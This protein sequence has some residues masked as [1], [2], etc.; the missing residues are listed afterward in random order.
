M[1]END[2]IYIDDEIINGQSKLHQPEQKEQINIIQEDKYNQ[3]KE[4][5]K[6]EEYQIKKESYNNNNINNI[7]EIGNIEINNNDDLNNSINNDENK[8]IINNITNIN[9]DI[10]VNSI[11]SDKRKSSNKSNK[12]IQFN[13]FDST[14]KDNNINNKIKSKFEKSNNLDNIKINDNKTINIIKDESI[15][16]NKKSYFHN[17]KYKETTNI[18]E[19]ENNLDK[20]EEYKSIENLLNY[21]NQRNNINNNKK[22]YFTETNIQNINYKNNNQKSSETISSIQEYSTK[23]KNDNYDNSNKQL[24][25]LIE[26]TNKKIRKNNINY[27][28][29]SLSP[30]IYMK[31]KYVNKCNLH[32]L[33]FRIKKIEEE[34]QKQNNYDFQKAIKD[35]QIKYDKEKKSKEKEKHLFELNKQLEEKL[36]LMEDK[37]NIKINEKINK[38]LK[39]QN[40]SNNKDK[41][42][43]KKKYLNIYTNITQ[44]NKAE[45]NNDINTID[46]NDLN[47]EKINKLPLIPN[48]SKHELI[49]IMK[50][51]SEE[52]FCLNTKKQIKENEIN[53]KKNYIRQLNMINDKLLKKNQLYKQRSEQCLNM[54]KKRELELQNYYQ[55]DM[56]KRYS[57]KEILSREQSAK[58]SRIKENL[59]KNFESVKEKKV[60]IENENEKKIKDILKK[61]NKNIKKDI[62]EN[63]QR[64]FFSHLQ[65]VNFNKCNMEMNKFYNDI[66]MR[67]E[68]NLLI[69]N[70]LQKDDPNIKQEIIKRSLQEQNQKIQQLKSLDKFLD[71]MDK[72]NINNKNEK[73]KIKVFKQIEI[74]KKRKEEEQQLYQ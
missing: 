14:D 53:H 5:K 58:S 37:R 39:K 41:K 12:K 66:I 36:K 30:Q 6:I 60:L 27:K 23:L 38:I 64:I 8:E 7:K 51:K 48:L 31:K 20:K 28:L 59:M 73:T 40:I 49:K 34:I 32:P 3:K 33:Q 46:S 35:L 24:S 57:I 55:K 56:L 17:K 9:K 69:I 4:E 67:H 19:S 62:N 22:L 10:E 61:L 15:Q 74:E 54:N 71:K 21:N 63:N 1:I 45:I 29:N 11:N 25:I 16:K 18:Q 72:E 44:R 52:E 65:K 26:E 70:D 43:L 13:L 68:D 2:E 50:D 42:Y 47:I